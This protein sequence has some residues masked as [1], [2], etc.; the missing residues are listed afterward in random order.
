MV[1]KAVVRPKMMTLHQVVRRPEK[2]EQR[3]THTYVIPPVRD[4]HHNLRHLIVQRFLPAVLL[5][6]V[7]ITV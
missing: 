7:G 4:G 6:E 3:R 1:G 2:L 5:A